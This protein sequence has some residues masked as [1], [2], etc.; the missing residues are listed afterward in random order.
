MTSTAGA[1]RHVEEPEQCDIC[2][3]RIDVTLPGYYKSTNDMTFRHST[4]HEQGEAPEGYV[5]EWDHD[6]PKTCMNKQ[7]NCGH[8]IYSPPNAWPQA[9][10]ECND[11]EYV[12]GSWEVTA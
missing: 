10:P 1:T 12:D 6:K 4:C 11:L 7:F 2:D 3:G 8:T 5:W 9:C